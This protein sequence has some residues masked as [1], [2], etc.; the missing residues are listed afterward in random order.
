MKNIWLLF[1]ALI[2]VSCSTEN[3]SSERPNDFQLEY[4]WETGSLP[5]PYFYS[6]QIFIGPGSKGEIRFQADYSGQDPPV[7]VESIEISE[8]ELDQLYQMLHEMGM[9]EKEWRQAADTPDGGSASK[10]SGIASG[11][12]FFIPSYVDNDQQAGDADA[13]YEFIETLVPQNTWKKL[14]SLHDEYVEAN[15]E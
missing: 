4:Y 6:Y 2:A 13:L 1:F 7:W 5:P 14:M 3:L 11:H 12:E 15:D 8:V 9:F 10:L